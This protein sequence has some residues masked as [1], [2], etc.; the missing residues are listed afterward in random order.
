[1]TEPPVGPGSVRNE[2]PDARRRGTPVIDESFGLDRRLIILASG[3]R[4]ATVAV[5]FLLGI[6]SDASG[7]AFLAAGVALVAHATLLTVRPAHLQPLDREAKL[8]VGIELALTITA[9]T[10]SGALDS[11]FLLTPMVPV[12]L[13]GFIWGRRQVVGLAIGGA[14][15]TAVAVMMQRAHPDAQRSAALLGVVLALC[16]AIGAFA[17]RLVIDI[18]ERS[19]ATLQEVARLATANDL[20]VALHRVAQTLPAS[21]DL[22]EVVDSIRTRLHSLFDFRAITILVRDGDGDHWHAALAEGIR[23][24]ETVPTRALPPPI[25]QAMIRHRPVAVADLLSTDAP[26]LLPTARSGLYVPL[27][28]RGDVAAML[29][30]EHDF[31]DRYTADD[32]A[33]LTELSGPLGL[34]LDNA[35]W[36]ARLRRS[37]AEAERARIARDLHD[38]LAQSLA[39]VA[40]ELERLAERDDDRELAGLREIVRDLVTELRETLYQLRA[41]VTPEHDLAEIAGPYLDRLEERTGIHVTWTCDAMRPLPFKVEKEVWRILQEALANVERHSDARHVSVQWSVTPAGA[42]LEVADDGCGFL[43]DEVPLDRYGLAGMH[44]RADAAGAVLT[45]GSSPG[46]GTRVS[47]E[48]TARR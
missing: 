11:P 15:A 37:G 7:V 5:G 2:S 3:L 4:W 48:L 28:A 14:L 9:A 12:V 46:N 8:G 10:V 40:F 29:A 20:L 6:L 22:V 38:R 16:G 30:V 23:L 41:D 47:V 1:M 17:R 31:P 13:A 19:A 21:L 24:P 42:L 25:R 26:G 18:A 39:Y 35:R 27:V 44:E 33:L 45:I 32:V 43:P 34:A 36:F